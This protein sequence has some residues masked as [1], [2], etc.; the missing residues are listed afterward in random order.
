MSLLVALTAGCGAGDGATPDPYDPPTNLRARVG[1]TIVV[2]SR[3]GIR[4]L[5]LQRPGPDSVVL[6]GGGPTRYVE[7]VT[8]P[9]DGNYALQFF[10]TG[11]GD[12]DRVKIRIDDPVEGMPPRR[13]DIG[14]DDFTIEFWLRTPPGANRAGPVT[15][16]ENVAWIGGNIVLD[17]DRYNAGRKFGLSLAGGI[18]VFG[19]TVATDAHRTIC[20]QRR[21]DDGLWHHV[22]VTRA[23]A[24]GELHLYVDGALEAGP[25]AG[26]PGDLSYPDRAIPGDFCRGPCTRSDPFLVLGAEKHDVGPDYPA[27]A[28]E[29][30]EL[31]LSSVIRYDG[32]FEVPSSAFVP[33]SATAAL[34]HFDEGAG[35]LVR[36]AAR[37][38]RE[39][40]PGFLRVGGARQGP[41]WVPSGAPTARR[42]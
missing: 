29:L 13:A 20:G 25:V 1:D 27:F 7:A 42:P 30:D 5:T 41:R 10:G 15:C 38:A 33:D 8:P 19:V 17:R 34:Y 40:S 37:P 35:E 31:R 3:V 16:G 39:A 36:D 9:P 22:A 24:S 28:G 12:V 6:G 32:P 18:V 4:E 21:I 26:P 23:L 2:R 11:S 14:G